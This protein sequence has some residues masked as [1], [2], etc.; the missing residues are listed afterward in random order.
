MRT[1]ICPSCRGDGEVFYGSCTTLKAK[2]E[3]CEGIGTFKVVPMG[4]RNQPEW[5]PHGKLHVLETY[6]KL[7]EGKVGAHWLW[8]ALERIANGEPE[9]EVMRDYEYVYL[10]KEK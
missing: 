8:V 2:C 10:P 4:N 9:I 7:H 1:L 6:K 5:R 3:Y